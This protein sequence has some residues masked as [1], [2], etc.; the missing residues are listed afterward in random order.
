MFRVI[1][2]V[3]I[4]FFLVAWNPQKLWYPARM[5]FGFIATPFEKVFSVV[6]FHMDSSFEFLS[7]IGTLKQ[8]NERLTQENRRLISENAKSS[9]IQKEN[10]VLRK[11]IGLLPRDAFRLAPAEVIGFDQQNAGNWLIIDKGSADGM[12]NGMIVIVDQSAVVGKI[13]DVLFHSSKVVLLTS[14]ESVIN[15]V[16]AQTEARGVVRGRYGLGIVM[17]TVLQTDVV[18]QGDDVITSGLGGDIPRGLF[19][20]KVDTSQPSDDR[21][22]QQVTLTPIVNILNLRTVF[23]ILD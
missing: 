1:I 21:L 5:M 7:S 19:L 8:E 16:D 18:K 15:G 2:I 6:G 20:G 10:E 23:V 17:D 4:L 22:F 3:G 13:S 14:P 12:R 9:D 11:E